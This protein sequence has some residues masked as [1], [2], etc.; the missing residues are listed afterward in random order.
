[1]TIP[2]YVVTTLAGAAAPTRTT[3]TTDSSTST[4][5]QFNY[6][7]SMTIDANNNLYVGDY[8]NN[9]LRYINVSP[10]YTLTIGGDGTFGTLAG[11]GANSKINTPHA[12]TF[13]PY[14]TLW[15]VTYNNG[16]IF[17]YNSKTGYFNLLFQN[18]NSVPRPINIQNT[19]ISTIVAPA[20]ATGTLYGS[21]YTITNSNATNTGGATYTNPVAL[22]MDPQNN[23]YVSDQYKIRKISPS[24]LVTSIYGDPSNTQGTPQVGTA[25]L[26]TAS[27]IY[28]MCFDNSGNILFTQNL[29]SPSTFSIGASA[30]YPSS[31]INRLNPNTGVLT[32]I[33]LSTPLQTPKGIAYDG[34]NTLYVVCT[35]VNLTAPLASYV[36]SINMTTG[37]VT[38]I[39][40]SSTQAG[41]AVGAGVNARFQ[42]ATGIC[43]DKAKQNLF[44]CDFNNAKVKKIVISTSEVSTLFS[45]GG[46]NFITMDAFSNLFIAA[47]YGAFIIYKSSPPYS[48]VASWA[49]GYTTPQGITVDSYNNVYLADSGT[50]VIY[51][52][53]PSSAGS[54]YSG[55]LNTT[56]TQDSTYASSIT[57]MAPYVGINTANPTA[58]LH[59]N[60]SIIASGNLNVTGGGAFQGSLGT[61]GGFYGSLILSTWITSTDGTIRLYCAAG[62]DTFFG[63]KTGFS[64]YF[65]TPGA[66]NVAY[67]NGISGTYN[68][69]SDRRIKKNIISATDTLDIINQIEF[70]SYDYIQE[71]RGSVKHGIVA[72]QLQK[73]YPDAVSV[74]RNVIPSHLVLVDVDVDSSGNLL[75]TCSAPHDLKVNDTVKLDIGDTYS[76]KVILEV[77]SERTFIVSK[78]DNFSPT[79]SVS[80]YGIYEDDVLSYDKSQIGILAAG[81]CQT[82][83]GQVSTLQADASQLSTITGEQFS[84]L[85]GDSSQLSTITGEQFSTLQGDSLNTSTITGEQVSTLQGDSLNQQSTIAALQAT[86][87]TILEK[88]P[89]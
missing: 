43:I 12:M 19:A 21:G 46:A 9:S 18:T 77:P 84:T 74:S 30:P 17:N 1:M 69:L 72:Q 16:A 67:I 55:V 20:I 71:A 49:T 37:V 66:G 5:V 87:T 62:G 50:K 44:V 70:V 34:V 76:E 35:N 75:I 31:V 24:G 41:D 42:N 15:V 7:L 80:L 2:G 59:V 86:I 56:G 79:T 61:T 45:I 57:L 29:L 28:G 88:Y 13:D 53:T 38:T 47:D 36:V 11:V 89:V 68:V 3:G 82:L 58:N 83:S 8:G 22:L 73:I 33:S 52:M 40:G 65:Q 85:Q 26:G 4:S 10:F 78:W 32:T 6:P 14:G 64:F 39:A 48:S 27:F 63:C 60:G 81:A 54:Y 51:S 23:L 25:T